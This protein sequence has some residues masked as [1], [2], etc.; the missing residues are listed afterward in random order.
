[1]AS[2]TRKSLLVII[3]VFLVYGTV[4]RAAAGAL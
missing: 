1:M 2:G 3:I 4:I